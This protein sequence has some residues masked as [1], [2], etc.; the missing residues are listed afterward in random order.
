MSDEKMDI[1][2][3]LAKKLEDRG[4]D[5][6]F[7]P[8]NRTY[9]PWYKIKQKVEIHEE[10]YMPTH[11]FLTQKI[12]LG[13]R[14]KIDG[15]KF[16]MDDL[17]DFFL[18]ETIHANI[19]MIEAPC[20][21]GAGYLAAKFVDSYTAVNVVAG[22]ATYFLSMLATDPIVDA[23]CHLKHGYSSISP[24][25]RRRNSKNS[26][27]HEDFEKFLDDDYNILDIMK[28]RGKENGEH[29]E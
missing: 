26:F 22:L 9:T 15:K 3:K 16:S 25:I 14:S 28:K 8:D 12:T 13:E 4:I 2:H 27:L 18:H 10:V 21:I 11:N 7:D 5:I 23:V 20:R 17:A 19:W 1:Y 24:I 29:R 6:P